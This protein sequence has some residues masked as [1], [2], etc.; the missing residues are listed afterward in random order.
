MLMRV[1]WEI[2]VDADTPREAAQRAL[3][4][5]QDPESIAT[6]FEVRGMGTG[7]GVG[8]EKGETGTGETGT[9]VTVDLLEG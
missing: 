7:R 4:I 9:G 6:V 8:G 2:D 3:E 5:M 1:T